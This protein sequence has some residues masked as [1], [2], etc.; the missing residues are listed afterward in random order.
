MLGGSPAKTLTTKEAVL[1]IKEALNEDGLYLT[2]IISSLE[3]ENSKFIRAE[4]NTLKKV[5]KNVYIVPCNNKD[6]LEVVQNNMVIA[7]DCD[8]LLNDNYDIKINENEI[9]LT[10]DYCPVDT[11]IPQK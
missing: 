2:N 7:T 3:G 8:L 10:D 4:V 1:K 9:I 6:D 11:L 5:F